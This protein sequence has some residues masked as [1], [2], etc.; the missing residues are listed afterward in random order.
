M[1]EQPSS[2]GQKDIF[3][4][5]RLFS[6]V[7]TPS[8][9]WVKNGI[10]SAE[11]LQRNWIRKN[12]T[13]WQINTSH[14]CEIKKIWIQ[15][16]VH[17]ALRSNIFLRDWLIFICWKKFCEVFHRCAKCFLYRMRIASAGKD[18]TVN[19]IRST[20]QNS[21]DHIAALGWNSRIPTF[22]KCDQCRHGGIQ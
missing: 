20:A 4:P 12:V 19:P 6:T 5:H 9:R 10:S 15:Q 22:R 11:E 1:R 17:I 16:Q 14:Y 18:R 21:K 7:F 13:F 8:N 2:T 3:R